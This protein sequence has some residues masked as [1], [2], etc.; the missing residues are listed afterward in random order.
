MK[1]I[2]ILGRAWR[3]LGDYRRAARGYR[4]SVP[5]ML[6]RAAFLVRRRGFTFREA[7]QEG[8]L[9]PSIPPPL[10]A[11]AIGEERLRALQAHVNPPERECLTE[12]KA[13]FYPYCEGLG[14]PVPRVYAV[15]GQQGGY[16]S[17]GRMLVGREAWVA[18]LADDLPE[19]CVLKPSFGFYGLGL[20]ILRRA[21]GTFVDQDGRILT[22]TA[23]YDEMSSAAG[24]KFRK[25]VFQERL[26][27]HA[28]LSRL[29]RTQAIQTIRILTFVEGGR[30][31]INHAF[32]RIITGR[33]VVDNWRHGETGNLKARVDLLEGCLRE[34][35]GPR[36]DR[37]GG[38]RVFKHPNT[39]ILLDGFRVPLWGEAKA[40]V[41]RAAVLFLPMRC[42]GWD[43]AITPSGPSLVEANMWWGP[44]GFSGVD[45]SPSSSGV[46]PADLLVRLEAAS[47]RPRV[48][49]KS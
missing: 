16:A 40:L 33:N 12:D 45:L 44:H 34:V 31:E 27:T 11:A 5:L 25:F 38:A 20:R 23:L 32:L 26:S 10:V 2:R 37:V 22:P 4:T 39:G 24:E 47:R 13:V 14:L 17:S 36:P 41:E 18:F 19:E 42:I 30:V 6:W 21:G 1:P 28:E 7:L 48:D 15:F 8:L 9:D 3:L 49:W 46:G 35:W 43:V 29:S